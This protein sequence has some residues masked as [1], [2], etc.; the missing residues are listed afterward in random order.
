LP[1][2]SSQQ[3]L[4]HADSKLADGDA[5]RGSRFSNRI[6]PDENPELVERVASSR[7]SSFVNICSSSFRTS[8]RCGRESRDMCLTTREFQQS[9]L[10][11]NVRL[12]IQP[13]LT[14][15]C[16]SITPPSARRV[17]QQ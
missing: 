17:Y 11:L 6:V 16:L 10:G 14:G 13:A 12:P 5:T 1:R 3:W 4:R 2:I 15:L 8:R 9:I 7:N